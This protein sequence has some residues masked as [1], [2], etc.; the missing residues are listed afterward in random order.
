MAEYY[1]KLSEIYRTFSAEDQNT[2][3]LA[4]K[5]AVKV[6][7]II[8]FKFPKS[9]RADNALW[10]MANLIREYGVKDQLSE[11]QCYKKIVEEYPNS[12]HKAEAQKRLAFLK[13]PGS[14]SPAKKGGKGT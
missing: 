4:L 11:E 5:V 8:V 7:E 6:L 14:P 13:R 3:K 12:A 10:G 1:F 2:R 9:D